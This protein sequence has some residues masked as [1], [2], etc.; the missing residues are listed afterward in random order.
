MR[1]SGRRRLDVLFLVLGA[2][3]TGVLVAF[4]AFIYNEE[5]VE[6]MW[7]G[8]SFDAD[9]TA[10]LH[11]VI[12][13]QFGS[14]TDR[15]GLLRQIPGLTTSSPIVVTSPDAPAGINSDTPFVFDAGEQGI[16]LKIGD[17][18]QT[19]SGEH[20]Y[21]L[22]YRHDG[23]T[24][25]S[26]VAWDAVGTGWDIGIEDTVIE[27]V[28]PFALDDVRCQ[29]G[30]RGSTAECDIDQPE[31]G[32]LRAHVTGLKD[33]HGVTIRAVRGDAL[34]A[35][36]AL[37]A[38]PAA[39]PAD[40]GAGVAEPA[41]V[42]ALAALGGGLAMS[43]KV[44]RAGR[45]RL[46]SAAAAGDAAAAAF[47]TQSSTSEQLVDAA[48]LADLAT[49]E[50]APPEGLSPSMGGVIFT[51]SVRAEHKVAWLIEAGIQGAV[52]LQEEG[53]KT[54]RIVRT[55]PGDAAT[56]HVLDKAFGG[57]DTITLG[58]YDA[59]FASG[60]TELGTTLEAWSKTS[61]LWDPAG[62]KRKFRHRLF[63]VLFGSLAM[64]IAMAGGAMAGRWGEGWLALD[65]VGAIGVGIAWAAIIRS[66]ELRVRTPQGS[67]MWLR[68]ESFRRFLHESEAYHAEEAA[69]R[70]VLREYTAWAV[71][72]GELDRWKRAV[73]SSTII[74]ESAGL[75]YVLLAPMLSSSTSHAST[76]P[77]SSGG[78]GGGGGV[79]GGGGGG[80]GGS[81]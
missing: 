79:G 66:W 24:D 55:A 53:G 12:D 75:N 33:H 51:E 1:I 32:H 72:L 7:V 74:P 10:A 45:E 21:V 63:G 43:R 8:A 69:K 19:V 16:E 65:V 31:P 2:L 57:R 77:S 47:G 76:A 27:L 36:P 30:T 48:D 5:R 9:G 17:A 34:A 28:A 70:G 56:Q 22:D 26:K 46:G 81:W 4:G 41:A 61:G 6:R 42:G 62:D 54:V 67:G 23:L 44:R 64:V 35:A 25:G 68:I 29:T 78:G 37:P 11:E 3:V 38:A 73:Q 60:W 20:R 80:G 18:N 49:T 58:K 39:P 40:P 50:F 52:D 59:T 15:H 14:A 13:Y 71:A